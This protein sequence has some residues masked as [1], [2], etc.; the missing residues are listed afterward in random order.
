MT[1]TYVDLAIVVPLEEE[2]AS[3]K[4][5]FKTNDEKLDGVQ[6]SAVLD[7][8]VEGLKVVAFLQ[9]GMGKAAASR[10]ATRIVENH[11]V[12]V[13]AVV[14]IAGG[15]SDDVAI[16]DV[17]FTGSIA[18]VLENVKI[19]DASNKKGPKLHFDPEFSNTDR[20]LTFAMQYLKISNETAG[21]YEEWQLDCLI[22]GEKVL[23]APFIGRNNKNEV[24]REPSAHEG[25]IVCG[26]VSKSQIYN[27]SLKDMDRKL[28]ALETESGGPF[29]V[30]EDASIPAVSI[31]GICDYADENKSKLEAQTSGGTRKIASINA[32]LYLKAQFSNP[33]FLLYLNGRRNA[34]NGAATAELFEK[35]SEHS[36][37]ERARARAADEADTQLRDLS[38]EYKG[39]P[40]GYR[41]PMPRVV[42]APKTAAA[43]KDLDRPSDPISILEAI[44]RDPIT[45][46]QA[47]RTYPD[48]SLPWVIATEVALV[49]I[50]GKTALPVVI[51]G[52]AVV[53]PRSSIERAIDPEIAAALSCEG[54]CPVFIFDEPPLGSRSRADYILEEIARYPNARVVFSSKTG[55][56]LSVPT[57]LILRSGAVRYKVSDISFSEMSDFLQRNFNLPDQQAGVIALKLKEA[58]HKFDLS[59][60]PS[61]FAGVAGD[62]L[63]SLLHA[64]RRAE[65]IQLAVLGFLSFVVVSDR[66]NIISRTFRERFLREVIFDMKV[67]KR[68]FTRAELVDRLQKL[69]SHGDYG[70][71][72][73]TFISSFVERGIIHFEDN[74]LFVT[75]PFV[76]SYLLAEELVRKPAEAEAYFSMVEEDFDYATFDIYCE[77]GPSK[78]IIKDLAAR[79]DDETAELRKGLPGQHILLSDEIRPAIVDK[80]NRLRAFEDR[81]KAA[82]DDVRQSRPNIGEKQRLLDIAA[83]VEGEA[84]VATQQVSKSDPPDQDLRALLERGFRV[85]AVAI[86]AIGA[87]SEHLDGQEKRELAQKIVSATSTLMDAWMRAFPKLETTKLKAALVSDPRILELF[88]AP[89]GETLDQS[90]VEFAEMV[91]DAYEFSLAG[92]PMRM[93]LQH[94]CDTAGQSILA[95]SLL[96]LPQGD[97]MEDLISSIWTAEITPEKAK[98]RLLESI[99]ALPPT[100]FLRLCISQHFMLRVFWN[101]WETSARMTLL[102][103]AEESVQ[104]IGGGKVDRARLRR[105][106]PD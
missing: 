90:Q 35:E 31:R 59:A 52:D 45:Y 81:I 9:D 58:F 16:G 48:N 62:V 86:V 105:I 87:A 13:M 101:Q 39:K 7:V 46:F 91:V 26:M 17:C 85:W 75:L 88:E 21:A 71:D 60:H 11:D 64:N 76:E 56:D 24:L 41:L 32:A 97:S 68:S 61:Y 82:F 47:P 106:L 99:R 18:D 74:K 20:R 27:S 96:K 95:G 14:G 22:R 30:A 104:P 79:L 53:P 55:S 44:V 63:M 100:P 33:N 54:V 84:R 69:S 70:I 98:D 12:G 19:S 94:L 34:A 36:V 57:D 73:L 42:A 92:H 83:R 23:K 66:K 50:E 89:E 37:V 3:L 10:T 80:R 40:R 67:N 8:G 6:Y 2:L 77:L 78:K 1:K 28:L 51:K 4:S 29:R 65:L 72:P 25:T 38:P 15:L 43:S 5:V 93:M 103:A 49:E 102:E